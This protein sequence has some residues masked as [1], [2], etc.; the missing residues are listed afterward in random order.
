MIFN[1]CF[2]LTV[3]L[4]SDHMNWTTY[5]KIRENFPHIKILGNQDVQDNLKKRN[6][7]QLDI[8]FKDDFQFQIGEVKFT[9]IQ[10]YHGTGEEYAE[11]HGLILESPSQNLLFATDLSTMIDYEKY[12]LKNN[13]KLDIILLEAN[14]DP[15]VIEF[16]ESAKYHSG[17]NLFSNGSS[18]HLSTTDREVFVNKFKKDDTIHVELHQSATYRSFEGL[19]KKLK[20]KLTLEEIEVWKMKN[21][22]Q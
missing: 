8:V 15:Q 9:T 12:L 18:R 3:I 11:T 2:T 17:Y 16:Y 4:E 6:L 7:P 5:K 22:K 14:Y 19:V 1:F 13:L 10:N 21:G 20:G